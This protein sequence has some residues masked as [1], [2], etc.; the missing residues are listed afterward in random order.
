ME[1]KKTAIIYARQS[2]GA[3]ENSLSCELQI[4]ACRAWAER[5]NVEIIGEYTDANTSSE[6]YPDSDEGRAYA[7]TDREWRRWASKQQTK[8]RRKYRKGLALAFE[9]LSKIDYFMP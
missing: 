5:N 8:G 7:T 4:K 9:Q 3:E 6:L 1:T 2:F